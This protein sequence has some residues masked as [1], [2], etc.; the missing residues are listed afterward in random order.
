MTEEEAKKAPVVHTETDVS[1]KLPNGKVLNFAVQDI[2]PYSLFAHAKSNPD[3]NWYTN[4]AIKTDSGNTIMPDTDLSKEIETGS[5]D[6]HIEI[7]QWNSKSVFQQ[8]QQ[9]AR[10]IFTLTKYGDC[11]DGEESLISWLI[12]SFGKSNSGKSLPK[13][14]DINGILPINFIKSD[15]PRLIKYFD[16]DK[17]QVLLDDQRYFYQFSAITHEKQKLT[18]K[19]CTKGFFVD[20]EG[21]DK[22]YNSLYELFLAHSQYFADNSSFVAVRWNSLH[23]LEKQP[24]D[25]LDRS[26][27]YIVSKKSN[28]KKLELFNRP[29]EQIRGSLREFL[30]YE[31]FPENFLL[32]IN[33]GENFYLRM[34]FEGIK[35]IANGEIASAVEG[36][37]TFIYNDVVISDIDEFAPFYA[38]EIEAR[39][40]ISGFAKTA[41][42]IQSVDNSVE[43]DRPIVVDYLGQRYVII[44]HADENC[45]FGYG[46]EHDGF[47]TDE[48]YKNFVEKLKA[49]FHIADISKTSRGFITNDG[50]PLLTQIGVLTPRDNNYPDPEKHGGYRVRPEIIRNFEIHRQLM[51]N[52]DEL[53][54]LGGIPEEDFNNSTMTDLEKLK[55]LSEFR[56]DVIYKSPHLEYDINALTINDE[57]ENSSA[58]ENLVEL[59]KYLIDV[60]IPKFVEKFTSST[61][62]SFDG[63]KL[64]TEMHKSGINV[65]YLG[66]LIPLIGKATPTLDSTTKII[67]CEMIIRSVKQMARLNKWDLEHILKS[68]QTIYSQGDG[69]D[70]LFEE[71]CTVSME[72]FGAKPSRPSNLLSTYL[73]R[74]LLLTFG[75]VLVLTENGELPPLEKANIHQ[76]N[77]HIKFQYSQ[78]IELNSR[79]QLAAN[80]YQSEN[81]KDAYKFFKSSAQIGERIMSQFNEMMMTCNYYIGLINFQQ[82]QLDA[83]FQSILSSL[84]IEERYIDDTNP[85]IIFKLSIL[86]KLATAAKNPR[87]AFAFF[88]R[89]AKSTQM[90]FPF[91]PWSV[92]TAA[93]A[94]ESIAAVDGNTAI[95]YAQN[96]IEFCKKVNGTPKM[97][98][99]TY[100]MAAVAALE[101]DKLNLAL[102][103]VEEA[104]KYDKSE[105]LSR[106]RAKITQKQSKQGSRRKP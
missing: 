74:S 8:A 79:V 78:S 89:A 80:L 67:E 76:I 32:A 106:I 25:P 28:L 96:A 70:Q 42:N 73:R 91:H 20:S 29:I 85:D 45:V 97:F 21:E 84:I 18:I 26:T 1:M 82:R 90:M 38:N 31:A 95:N 101:S 63:R 35:K 102:K 71:I 22:C 47:Q 68:I 15:Q 81:L 92:Q 64:T 59:G 23:L 27:Y 5:I 98:G 50:K 44:Y 51:D 86:G 77:P 93:D 33:E 48:R 6:A 61:P 105:D 87:L 62:Y 17:E 52:K 99:N 36:H 83:A 39:K 14:A 53:I 100:K 3:M 2:V 56:A 69:F 55:K 104:A 94:A 58:P 30:R 43:I 24:F 88:S 46:P 65:R 34:I 41:F 72:K 103:F 4:F 66:K 19:S 40:E 12:R 16:L 49:Q 54:A 7:L 9:F 11:S 60:A 57:R 75:I 10:M 37:R 13:D